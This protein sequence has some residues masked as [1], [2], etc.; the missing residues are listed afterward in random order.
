MN[1]FTE[2]ASSEITSSNHQQLSTKLN[3]TI[4]CGYEAFANEQEKFARIIKQNEDL[5]L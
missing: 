3:V 1:L 5:I 4:Y 2:I